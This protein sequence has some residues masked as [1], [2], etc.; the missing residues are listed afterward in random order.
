MTKIVVQGNIDEVVKA[1][2]DEQVVAFPTETVYGLGVKFGSSEALEKLMTAKNRDYSKAITL[3]VAHKEDIEKYADV[4]DTARKLI[5][6][7]MPGM[8]TLVLR[9]KQVYLLI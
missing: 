1:I 6:A 9:K 7:F 3:M 5:S 8:I 2:Q 4:S